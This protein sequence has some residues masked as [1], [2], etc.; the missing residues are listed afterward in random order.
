MT[1]F[2][3]SCEKLTVAKRESSVGETLTTESCSRC[4]F[5]YCWNVSLERFSFV[6]KLPRRIFLVK[7]FRENCMYILFIFF[8][9][10]VWIIF[11]H[12][13]SRSFLGLHLALQGK[14]MNSLYLIYKDSTMI[15]Y[16][17]IF[18]K[19]FIILFVLSSFFKLKNKHLLM[20]SIFTTST[21]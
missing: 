17:L 16:W 12:F 15:M 5:H 7:L 9:L 14:K 10:F 21:S 11:F 13:L 2:A 8:L 4:T 18:T 1:V 20:S 19:T 3:F 6:V